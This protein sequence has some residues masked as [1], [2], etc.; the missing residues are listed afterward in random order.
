MS[1]ATPAK[2]EEV[3]DRPR[4]AGKA[5]RMP[6]GVVWEVGVLWFVGFVVLIA[7]TLFVFIGLERTDTNSSVRERYRFVLFDLRERLESNLNLGFDLADN[8]STQTLLDELLSRDSSFQVI[9]VFDR[10]GLSIF[11]TDRGSVGEKV[12]ERWQRARARQPD[13]WMV[14]GELETVV[15]IPIRNAFDETAGYLALTYS[16]PKS[17][18][19]QREWTM[20]MFFVIAALLFSIGALY[21]VGSNYVGSDLMADSL[22]S[23]SKTSVV[24]LTDQILDEAE[25]RLDR[26]LAKLSEDLHSEA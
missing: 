1:N 6:V 7:V 24:V 9:E 17:G 18:W 5:S 8:P 3:N 2:V 4:E 15:G 26:A 14:Q 20:L 22:S 19:S 11:S 12:P 25:M 21:F 16:V 23:G 10:D 13:G